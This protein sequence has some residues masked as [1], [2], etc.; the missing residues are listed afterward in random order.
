MHYFI[1][2]SV[3]KWWSIS[4]RFD[5]P[6]R[7]TCRTIVL[8]SDAV[9]SLVLLM[10]SLTINRYIDLWSSTCTA[11]IFFTALLGRLRRIR[12]DNNILLWAINRFN[13]FFKVCWLSCHLRRG[14]AWRLHFDFLR[15]G[16]C[17]LSCLLLHMSRNF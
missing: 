2:L 13:L 14:I 5:M 17:L 16:R 3:L 10:N 7:R 15:L 4:F 1:V 8:L 12:F 9:V 11:R 6:L